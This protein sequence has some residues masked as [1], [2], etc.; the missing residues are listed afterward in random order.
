MIGIIRSFIIWLFILL[1]ILFFTPV[2]TLTWLTTVL[3]DSRLYLLSKLALFW[4]SL[5]TRLNPL[6][7]VTVIGKEKIKKNDTYVV[8]ANHQALEDIIVMYRL[9]KPFRWVSKADVFKIP[10]FGWAMYLS[11]DIKLNRTSKTS[12]KKM[13]VDGEQVLKKGITLFIFPEGT[14]SKNGQLGNFKEGAFKLAQNTRTP[15]LPVFIKG[16]NDDLL[17]KYGIFKGKHNVVLKVMNPIPYSQFKDIDTAE[18]AK[19]VKIILE[20]EQNNFP[21]D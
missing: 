17:S 16:T 7:N 12:I 15:I 4:G 9:G 8:V 14:R 3:F 6:W 13:I 21:S 2:F 5:Y 18:L 10:F 11:G 1:T 19:Q 20:K